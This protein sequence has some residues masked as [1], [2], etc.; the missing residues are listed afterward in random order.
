VDLNTFIIAVFC[1]VDDHV[2]DLG[3]LRAR[4][5]TP[6][7]CDSEVITIEIVG[8]FL[9]LDEDTQ[10]FAY[11]RRHYPHYFLRP[12]TRYKGRSVD[13]RPS[14]LRTLNGAGAAKRRNS[15][16]CSHH[17]RHEYRHHQDRYLLRPRVIAMFSPPS[18]SVYSYLLGAQR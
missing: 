14:P 10:L 3:R 15:A 18:L 6:T 9:G 1:L 13:A 7:L 5:P 2:A 16:G 4:G 8:E 12:L 17:Q 11:F